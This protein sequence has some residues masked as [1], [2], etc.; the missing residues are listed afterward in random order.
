MAELD[1]KGRSL[2]ILEAAYEAATAEPYLLV[3]TATRPSLP[4]S[5]RL[6]IAPCD[7]AC[8]EERAA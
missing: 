4:L 7:R 2:A 3:I 6:A 8:P 5:L 1:L